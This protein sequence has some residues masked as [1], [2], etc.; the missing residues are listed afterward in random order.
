MKL[1]SKRLP[2]VQG[3]T[4]FTLIELLVVIAII[5]ILAAI[6]FPVFGKAREKARQTQ[7]I[8]NQKQIALAVN[9]F[10]QE[11]DERLPAAGTWASDINIDAKVLACPSVDQERSNC[12]GYFAFLSNTVLGDWKDADNTVLIADAKDGL[13]PANQLSFGTDIES[14]HNGG[15]IMGYLDGHV[16]YAK[17][18]PLSLGSNANS[19]MSGVTTT[20]VMRANVLTL[21]PP[22]A[23]FLSTTNSI[24][25]TNNGQVI[26][27]PWTLNINS[28]R[29]D[30]L[31]TDAFGTG[32][33]PLVKVTD[34]GFT[35]P[36]NNLS[37]F[38][39]YDLVR[40]L[41]PQ[42]PTSPTY[43]VISGKF[44]FVKNTQTGGTPPN[45][46]GYW[47]NAVDIRV[48]LLSNTG[49]TLASFGVMNN[50]GTSRICNYVWLS[51]TVA[52]QP[53]STDQGQ[54]TRLT[55]GNN[56]REKYVWGGTL[57]F[58]LYAKDG[59][60]TLSIGEYNLSRQAITGWQS[61]SKVRIYFSAAA[62]DNNNCPNS[63]TVSELSYEIR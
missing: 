21:A 30:R 20:D 48:E 62:G 16:A 39:R 18:V 6:L 8:S 34:N 37:Y 26:N 13:T 2:G 7:C 55:D 32:N 28:S 42:P 27:G 4:G 22:S 9:L 11:N 57:P 50:E 59:T 63:V 29:A 43:W 23:T 52:N 25:T 44:S 15:A 61:P 12:Y 1:I 58:T 24:S 40:D 33:Y 41:D 19:Q 17:P 56:I 14:R 38:S 45:P 46:P 51:D 53:F 35:I 36:R 60:M 3:V 31:W 5:A 49:S 54:Q 47:E 10:T